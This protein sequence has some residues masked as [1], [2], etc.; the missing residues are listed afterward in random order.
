[1][2]RLSF[3]QDM[4]SSYTELRGHQ[5]PGFGVLIQHPLFHREIGEITKPFTKK[6]KKSDPYDPYTRDGVMDAQG[7][8]CD[9]PKL[10]HSPAPVVVPEPG[11]TTS[12]GTIQGT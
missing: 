1:M 8:E 12:Q 9:L 10:T 6:K 4:A 3:G 5:Q 7:K 2:A 11:T